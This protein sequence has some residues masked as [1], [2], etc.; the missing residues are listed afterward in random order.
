MADDLVSR[1]GYV[2][3]EMLA[4]ELLRACDEK[5][6]RTFLYSWERDAIAWLR[7]WQRQ[8]GGTMNHW[9]ASYLRGEIKGA[10]RLPES[11]EA[12]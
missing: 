5:P 2:L 12:T 1:A 7:D 3:S 9:T 6:R 8:G 11:P 10:P 4:T